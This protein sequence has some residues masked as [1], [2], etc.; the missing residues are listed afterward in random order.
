MMAAIATIVGSQRER[1]SWTR[2]SW[3]AA[4][5]IDG[6]EDVGRV[7]GDAPMT[8]LSTSGGG[9]VGLGLAGGGLHELAVDLGLDF[10]LS[11]RVVFLSF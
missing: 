10:D 11:V 9:F 4:R 8:V 2:C 7:D 3:T 1:S 5:S 6:V